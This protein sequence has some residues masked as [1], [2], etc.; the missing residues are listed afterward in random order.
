MLL[1][2]LPV[3][4]DACEATYCIDH[5]SYTRHNCT[6][7]LRKDVQVP[8]CPLC[9]EPVPTAKDVAPDITV[10]RHID[11]FCKLETRKIYTNQCSMRGCKKKELIPVLC[12]QCKRNFCLG[13]RHNADHNCDPANAVRDQRA[14]A[15]T[16]RLQNQATRQTTPGNH[17]QAVQGSMSEDEALAHALALSMQGQQQAQNR[18]NNS[19]TVGGGDSLRDKCSLS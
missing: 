15:A 6:S 7:G 16:R 13:H 12:S 3:R 10:G 11:Q 5:Y 19:V 4:C 17:A 2:F 9:M 14:D 1:D 18:V 8:V